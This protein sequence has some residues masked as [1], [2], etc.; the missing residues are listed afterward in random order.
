[1]TAFFLDYG[2]F[3]AK[4]ATVVFALGLVLLM[5]G[6]A[7]RS[8]QDM[9][10]RLEVI[11]LNRRYSSMAQALQKGT[12]PKP[13]FKKVYKQDKK[14]L[15]QK[16]KQAA[17]G[18]DTVRKRI[19]VVDFH[20]DI[21]ATAVASLRE[22]VSAILME[23]AA[24]DEVVLRLENAGGMV[25]EH[26]LAASQLVRLRE[27]GI[28]LLVSV[29]KIAASGGYLMACV[30][31][32]IIAAPFAILGSI[33]VLAQMPNFHE[34]LSRHGIEF[35]QI[36]AGRYKRT[37][38]LFGENT[39]EDRSKMQAQID[40]IHSLFQRFVADFRPQLDMEQVATG[41]YWYGRQ[42]LDLKLIDALQTSDDYLVNT[43]TDADIY[44]L[45]YS[46]KKRLSERFLSSMHQAVTKLFAR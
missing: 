41:E 16:D 44:L 35:E 9:P 6:R 38:T 37:M 30:A 31:D 36:K 7:R 14:E 45:K 26:G 22:T 2:L 12:L 13:L 19:F 39:E 25:H 11:N 33:G 15:K 40:E 29:D 4:T 23:A 17:K 1:M 21:K 5:I 27:K 34:L 46:V 28:P 42:A 8:R 43:S 10:E 18:G 24:T 32:R 20:G 3:L